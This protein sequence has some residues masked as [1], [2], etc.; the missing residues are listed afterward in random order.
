MFNA[1]M[2]ARETKCVLILFAHPVVRKSRVNR[3]LM[4]EVRGLESVT[5]HDLYETYPDFDIDAAREQD[6]LTRHDVVVLQ[7]PFYWY[8]TPA[9]LKEWQDV[10]LEHGWAYGRNGHALEGKVLLNAVTAGGS[11]ESYRDGG[12]NRYGVRQLLAPIEQTARLCGMD[13]LPPFVIFGTHALSDDEIDEA[14]AS[15]R[16]LIVALR[17]GTLDLGSSPELPRINSVLGRE[18]K[19]EG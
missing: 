1:A 2:A 3:R 12:S 16:R 9:I 4:E 19:D 10:V 15:F 14:A 5:F 11:E 17:E 8:S 13:Y 7:H 18:P 6:L